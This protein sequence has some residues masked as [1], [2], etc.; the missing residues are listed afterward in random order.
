M[1]L[2]VLP[3]GRAGVPEYPRVDGHLAARLPLAPRPDHPQGARGH[4]VH[5]VVGHPVRVADRYAEPAEVG[6]DDVEV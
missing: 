4:T 2:H 5:G 6:P 3:R 1:Y